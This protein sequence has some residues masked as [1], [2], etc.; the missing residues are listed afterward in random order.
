MSDIKHPTIYKDETL[1]LFLEFTED[2]MPFIHCYVYKWSTEIYKQHK[3]IWQSVIDTLRAKGYSTIY[4]GA[5]D[6]K[7]VKFAR[8]FGFEE[9]EMLFEDSH[10]NI[11]RI[12]KC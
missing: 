1:E 6:N 8:M 10:H 7:L 4:A 2:N 9:T 5:M 3:V 12:L 11:R